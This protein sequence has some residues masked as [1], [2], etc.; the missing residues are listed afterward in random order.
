M[1]L[2]ARK[3][4]LTEQG[5]HVATLDKPEQV[6]PLMES[7]KFDLVVTDYKMPKM[8]GIELISQLREAGH[9]QPIVLMSG[10]VEALGLNEAST[11]A[12]MVIQKSANE[13]P[14]LL[15]AVRALLTGRRKQPAADLRRN[16]Q[17]GRQRKA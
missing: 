11:G 1:G 13:V 3:T 16:G 17:A 12:N 9:K 2:I 4:V 14:R 6:L 15:H 5:Y 10:F 8:T 7:E